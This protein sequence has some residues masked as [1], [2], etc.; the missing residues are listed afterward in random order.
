MKKALTTSFILAASILCGHSVFAQQVAPAYERDYDLSE[1]FELTSALNV[2][3]Q[4][5]LFFKGEND[6]WIDLNNNQQFEEGEQALVN[7]ANYNMYTLG[8]QT[9]RIYGKVKEFLCRDERLGFVINPQPWRP[10]PVLAHAAIDWC[11]A[12]SHVYGRTAFIALAKAYWA[13]TTD[14]RDEIQVVETLHHAGLP[15]R[16]LAHH[17]GLKSTLQEQY[18]N[19]VGIRA[20][21]I[22]DAPVLK[23]HGTLLPGLLDPEAYVE[24]IQSMG[25]HR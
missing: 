4:V 6:V 3:Q 21:H 10:C 19:L 11:F 2:G 20:A 13:N 1:Y 16:G 17:L 23:V 8:S 14:I 24:I 7:T 5:K 15:I 22:G 9:I 12:Q 25:T 18:R